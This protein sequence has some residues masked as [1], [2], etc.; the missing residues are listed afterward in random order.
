VGLLKDLK[1]RTKDIKERQEE[2]LSKYKS[3]TREKDDMQ[4]KYENAIVQLRGKSNFKNDVL[5]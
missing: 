3:S 2:L 4:D 5:E 1:S